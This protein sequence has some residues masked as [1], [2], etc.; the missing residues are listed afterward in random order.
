MLLLLGEVL[1]FLIFQMLFVRAS[2]GLTHQKH[3]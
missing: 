3:L 1:F 2:P